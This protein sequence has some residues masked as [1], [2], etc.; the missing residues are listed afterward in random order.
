MVMAED[1]L[2]DTDEFASDF[3]SIWEDEEDADEE[4]DGTDYNGLLLN[5]RE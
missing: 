1:P 4:E 5:D 3:E 2:S